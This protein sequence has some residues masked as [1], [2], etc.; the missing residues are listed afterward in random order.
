[1]IT[2]VEIRYQVK[3]QSSNKTEFDE[4]IAVIPLPDSYV[5]D[6]FEIHEVRH[7]FQSSKS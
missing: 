1:M 4:K 2:T 6:T 5:T 3:I 7:D